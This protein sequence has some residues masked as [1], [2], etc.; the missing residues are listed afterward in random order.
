[1]YCEISYK[2][3]CFMGATLNPNLLRKHL[4]KQNK[5]IHTTYWKLC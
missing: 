3:F 4:Y 2:S 1:M 5:Y